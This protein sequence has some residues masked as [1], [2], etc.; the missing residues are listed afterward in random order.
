MS[1][2]EI[3]FASNVDPWGPS[4]PL[5]NGPAAKGK[6]SRTEPL[7]GGPG[8]ARQKEEEMFRVMEEERLL[9]ELYF[10]VA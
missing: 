4:P 10:H 3:A 6:P 8:W 1:C 5:P 9:N 2:S 7:P